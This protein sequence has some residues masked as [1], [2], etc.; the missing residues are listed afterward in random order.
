MMQFIALVGIVGLVTCVLSYLYA[1][2]TIRRAEIGDR[3]GVLMGTAC[4]IWVFGL[5]LAFA[6]TP[7]VAVFAAGPQS[8][9][10]GVRN[11]LKPESTIQLFVDD[12]AEPAC[13]AA[14]KEAC[15][16]AVDKGTHKI[17]VKRAGDGKV[18]ATVGPPITANVNVR[19]QECK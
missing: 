10:I 9:W 17:T 2:V 11:E 1:A 12:V 6:Q 15:N 4:G 16:V 3:M 8:A 7:L 18:C 5:T 14:P 13:E 19:L